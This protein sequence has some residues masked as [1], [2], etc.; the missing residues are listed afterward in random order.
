MGPKYEFTDET[1]NH[2]GRIL[3]RIRRLSD[4]KIGGWIE[5]EENL[6]QEGN[7]WVDDNAKV[8]KN[9]QVYGNAKIY[10]TA[11]I[12][13][14]A[15]VFGN[16][17][18]YGD[19]YV[20]DNA[21]VYDHAE[22]Y[23][24]GSAHGNAKVYGHARIYGEAYAS[25]NAE[26]YDNAEIYYLASVYDN[27]K[28]YGNAKV[29]GGN[30]CDIKGNAQ[31]YDSAQV[32]DSVSV[33]GDAQIYGN[34][35]L[36]DWVKVCGNAKIFGNAIIHFSCR[37]S[38]IGKAI[39]D[40]GKYAGEDYE[41]DYIKNENITFVDNAVKKVVQDFIYKVDDSN[42]LEVYTG[43][44][45]IEEFFNS[46][47][48][49]DND[50]N[51]LVICSVDTKLPLIKLEKIEKENKLNYR[52]IVDITIDNGDNFSIKSTIETQEQLSQKLKQTVEA[53]KQYPEFSKYANDL[54][55][56]L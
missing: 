22:I 12:E 53:L 49:D 54:E 27:A 28:V 34:A 30:Y 35:Y 39:I 45:S 36:Y 31:V 37:D 38:I 51:T 42:K 40:S 5:S 25:H 23:E 41:E 47:V 56:Y 50:L 4:G 8:Y 7:C 21:K 3:H 6:S 44:N 19:A 20:Y 55:E 46:D 9:A 15:Q 24:N 52:F 32:C 11:V 13:D 17:K 18:I 26:V 16:A 10:D 43:Y 29:H 14:S 48:E 1:M 2:D 33:Y